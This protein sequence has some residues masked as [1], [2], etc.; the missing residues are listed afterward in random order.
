MKHISRLAS[1]A[2]LASFVMPLAQPAMKCALKINIALLLVLFAALDPAQ[3]QTAQTQNTSVKR[4]SPPTYVVPTLPAYWSG[5]TGLGS[6]ISN[7]AVAGQF[8]NQDNNTHAALFS[9]DGKSFQDL[10]ILPGGSIS[11]ARAV[12]DVGQ[13]V[14]YADS[15]LSAFRAVLFSYGGAVIEIPSLPDAPAGAYAQ[16]FAS[17]INNLGQVV[18]YGQFGFGAEPDHGFMYQNGK[19]SDLG[20]NYTP[21]AINASGQSVGQVN[22]HAAFFHDGAVEDLGVLGGDNFSVALAINDSGSIVASSYKCSYTERIPG[23]FAK[24]FSH[25]THHFFRVTAFFFR[26]ET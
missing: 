26:T 18:G 22:S 5:E 11:T 4:T 19:L 8:R 23:C 17:G 6:G 7:A 14:G 9:L 25:Q 24:D 2:L 20:A 13:A 12:N 16:T 21:L 10:G 1:G 3:T 15:Q